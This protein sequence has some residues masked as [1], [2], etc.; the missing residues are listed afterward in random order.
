MKT[1][2]LLCWGY[3]RKGWITPFEHLNEDFDFVYLFYTT[4]EEEGQSFTNCKKVYW[5]QFS[6]AQQILSTVKPD[7]IVFMSLYSGYTMALNAAAKR[8][9]IHTFI[10]QH[11][12]YKTYQEYRF[13]ELMQKEKEIKDRRQIPDLSN[14]S[15]TQLK[16]SQKRTL[17]FIFRSY[18]VIHWY[19]IVNQLFFIFVLRR[20]GHYTAMK[21]VRFS[22]RIP[23]SYICFTE[24]NATIHKELDKISDEIIDYTGV[25]ELDV[26]FKEVNHG[27]PL[28]EGSYYLMVSQPFA[29]NQWW[30]L[31]VSVEQ[32]NE[33]CTKLANWCSSNSSKL[34]VKLHPENYESTW[35]VKHSNI[36]YAK[37]LPV[38]NLMHFAQGVFGST[39]TLMLPAVYNKPCFLLLIHNSGFQKKVRELGLARGADYLNFTQDE[40]VF[41]TNDDKNVESLEEFEKK[42]LF[43]ADGKSVERLREILKS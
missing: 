42:Y 21:R 17:S 19:K 36:I 43:K 35:L 6:C 20:E 38:A 28:I 4:E 12:L 23:D 15:D 1:R 41:K 24:N 39:S 40:I 33:V 29:Q 31:G 14:S 11:G 10:F 3:H 34:V 13:F 22:D 8:K 9:G 16:K 30:N 37:E 27:K 26:F 2:I 18:S 32:E 5:S 7:K 25:P